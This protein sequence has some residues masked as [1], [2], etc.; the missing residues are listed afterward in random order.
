MIVMQDNEILKN[1]MKERKY[2]E[3]IA[4]LKLKIIYYI[5]NAIKQK[6]SSF[7]FTT[8]SDLI[9]AS[10]FYLNDS[11]IAYRLDNALIEE[12]PLKQIEALLNICEEEKIK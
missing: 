12:T 9:S 4:I 3:C 7:D 6:D 5:I 10:N 2:A 1:Y 8:V 11:S